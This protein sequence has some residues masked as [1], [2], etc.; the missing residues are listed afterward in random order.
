MMDIVKIELNELKPFIKVAYKG[1][2]D[3]LTKYHVD[4][5]DLYGAVNETLRM[6]EITSMGI[7]MNY[8]GVIENEERI[9]YICT[10]T[11]NLYSFGLN[12]E[13]R[14]K[15]NLIEFWKIIKVLLGDSFIT[16]LYPNNTRAINWLQKCGMV[17][18]DDVEDNCVV[19]LNLPDKETIFSHN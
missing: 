4:N 17:I 15:E 3:L 6:V 8:Y 2:E 12:I 18:V 19:L 9:G 14:T 11:N 1:D 13:M 10:F 7:E 16:M 5:Y